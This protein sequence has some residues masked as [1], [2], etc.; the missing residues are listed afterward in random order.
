M[1][2]FNI[3][4]IPERSRK[5]IVHDVE[6]LTGRD[7]P[8]LQEICLFGSVARGDYKWNSDIDLAI[9]TK[10]AITDHV[11]RG[12]VLDELDEE[13]DG[14]SSDV[15]FRTLNTHSLSKTFD[16]AFERDKVVLWKQQL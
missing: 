13:I 6:Y 10:R 9:I 7:I 8:G 4:K 2:M 5:K 16:A 12:E 11:L 1:A 3:E 14:V 15:V